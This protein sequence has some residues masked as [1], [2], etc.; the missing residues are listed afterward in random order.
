MGTFRVVTFLIFCIWLGSGAAHA[1]RRVA[2]VIGNSNY[3]R[4]AKLP[5]PVNDAGAVAAMLK[6]AGFDSVDARLDAT[7][8]GLRK[9]LRDFAAKAREAEVAVVYYAGHGIG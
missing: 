6:A 1:E 2:L 4:V 3:Q 9:A 8:N 5:N 7:A